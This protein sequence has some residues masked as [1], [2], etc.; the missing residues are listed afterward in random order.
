MQQNTALDTLPFTGASLPGFGDTSLTHS[1]QFTF[2][3]NHIFSANTLNEFRV[4]YTRLNFDAVEPQKP[5]LPSSLGF[6]IT[7][8]NPKGAGAPLIGITG[9]FTLGFS[10]NG[11]QPRIDQTRQITDNFSHIAGRHTL[12]VWG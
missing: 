11:P 7:P 6:N 10:N 12:E 3:E 5:V 8:Q 9:Y 1:K 2:A 4:G